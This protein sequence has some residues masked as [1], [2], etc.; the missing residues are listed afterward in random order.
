[1]TP[2]FVCATLNLGRQKSTGTEPYDGTCPNLLWG[3]KALILVTSD[4]LSGLLQ[5][6]ELRFQTGGAY[7]TLADVFIDFWYI[8]FITLYYMFV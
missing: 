1:M 4:R 8:V 3:D 5:S 6:L 2:S 7:P